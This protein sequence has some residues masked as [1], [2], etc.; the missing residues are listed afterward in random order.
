MGLLRRWLAKLKIL[1]KFIEKSLTKNMFWKTN[2]RAESEAN[3]IN[4][5]KSVY[6][7]PESICHSCRTCDQLDWLTDISSIYPNY[8]GVSILRENSLS[9]IKSNEQNFV[10]NI[11]VTN[12][13]IVLIFICQSFKT[14]HFPELSH[15]ILSFFYLPSRK[16]FGMREGKP[17]FKEW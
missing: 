17:D 3:S 2:L 14:A 11:F 5:P 12:F 13:T 8:V 4:L 1:I 15:L 10:N 9:I 6:W 16:T 7:K